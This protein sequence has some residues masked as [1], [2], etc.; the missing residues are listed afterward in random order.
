M[1]EITIKITFIGDSITLYGKNVN[2]LSKD[3]ID[4][5]IEMLVSLAK[6]QGILQE[7]G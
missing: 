7:E 1:K 4:D 6:T 3:D 2:E 5:S